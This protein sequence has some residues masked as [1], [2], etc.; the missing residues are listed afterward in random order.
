MFRSILRLDRMLRLSR[1][2][3]AMAIL[4]CLGLSGCAQW[5]TRG[6]DYQFDPAFELGS[7]YRAA[8]RNLEPAAVSNKGMQ[9][10]RSLGGP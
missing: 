8:D 10:E 2:M 6:E 1:C 5:G 7:R 3:L 9:I 4:G